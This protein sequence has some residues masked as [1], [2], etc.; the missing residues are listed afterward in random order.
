MQGAW[1]FWYLPGSP[2]F[3]VNWTGVAEIAGGVG[4]AV[5]ALHL[6][7]LPEWLLPA[8]AFGLFLLTVAVSPSNMYMWT[9]NAAPLTEELMDA[10]PGGAI[11]WQVHM[12][13]ATLQVRALSPPSNAENK[14]H[15]YQ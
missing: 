1:G 9:H 5:G 3:H 15:R 14:I 4:T 8:S 11:S 12:G 13:R 7:F 6:P 10:L 2:S